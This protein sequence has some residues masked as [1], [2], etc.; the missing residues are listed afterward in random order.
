MPFCIYA[1]GFYLFFPPSSY[2][3]KY[4]L[5]KKIAEFNLLLGILFI[6][7]FLHTVYYFVFA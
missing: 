5:K 3:F 7:L 2:V 1:L 6:I 4:Y